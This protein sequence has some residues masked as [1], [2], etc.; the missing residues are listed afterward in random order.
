MLH[1]TRILRG[2]CEQQDDQRQDAPND[3]EPSWRKVALPRSLPDGQFGTL[4]LTSVEH[5]VGSLSC[6]LPSLSSDVRVHSK[7]ALHPVLFYRLFCRLLP[8]R[9]PSTTFITRSSG[10]FRAAFTPPPLIRPFPHRA[11]NCFWRYNIH[12]ATVRWHQG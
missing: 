6:D 8:S 9:T 4:G 3:E 7:A 2:S 1:R 11:A 10:F 5:D 12:S